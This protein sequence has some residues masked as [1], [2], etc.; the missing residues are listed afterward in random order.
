MRR[1]IE[2]SVYGLVQGVGYRAFVCDRARALDLV[3]WVR[4]ELDG[5]V[6]GQADGDE[7]D[8]ALFADALGKGPLMAH[9]ERHLVRYLP[10][11]TERERDFRI[12]R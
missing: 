8:I 5:H 3:G 9:V 12:E 7:A 2:F 4:N 10:Y 11:P 6:E 1:R